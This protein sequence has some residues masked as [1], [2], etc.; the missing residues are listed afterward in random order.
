MKQK[1]VMEWGISLLLSISAGWLFVSL[2]LQ[3]GKAT[4]FFDLAGIAATALWQQFIG[5][6][7]CAAGIFVFCYI[8]KRKWMAEIFFLTAAVLYGIIASMQAERLETGLGFGITVLLIWLFIAER[9]KPQLERISM[10]GK[11]W[12]IA[13]VIGVLGW[14]LLIG[15]LTVFRYLDLRTPCFDFGIFSQMF[16]YMRETGLP[17]TTCERDGLLSHF[18]VHVS[19]SL[20]LLLPF[21]YVFPYPVTL[22]VLQVAIIASGVIPLWKIGKRYGLKDGICAGFSIVYL[23]FPA[24]TGGCFYDFHENK[25]L[26]PLILWMLYALE[27]NSGILFWILAVLVL[28]VKEDAAIYV[29]CIG[30]YTVFGK[31]QWKRGLAVFVFSVLWFFSVLYYLQEYGDGAMLGRYDNYIESGGGL[32]SLVTNIIKNPAYVIEQCFT[33]GKIKFMIWM[34]APLLGIMFWTKQ[35]SN[36]FLLIPFLVINLMSNNP[37][38]NSIYYQYTYGVAALFLFLAVK[39]LA[40]K[41]PLV[42]KKI[43][44]SMGIVSLMLFT[45]L[46][47]QKTYYIKEYRSEQDNLRLMKENMDLIPAE[48]S[49]E[50]TTYVLPYLSCRDEIYR[51]TN[52]DVNVV[53]AY[54]FDLRYEEFEEILQD[55][56]AQLKKDGYI[57]ISNNPEL[58]TI[59]YKK[60]A[61]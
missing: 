46:I 18:A 57:Q 19:P 56:E 36:Y 14:L 54:V 5:T 31:K 32:T 29:A 45:A 50:A 28:G 20:Y 4:A 2:F 16:Y 15:T 40:E 51:M 3:M 61:E 49:V 58:V 55:R 34:L 22:L 10:K 52:S 25:L 53:N 60:D 21:Y 8:S 37:Y 24:I 7:L 27:K 13:A 30:L 6:I 48:A 41:Q 59:Y 17:L 12:V 43:V 26:L 33:E 44:V 23:L 47:S 35:L 39:V 11:I 42:Q 38:Q 1:Q 9:L